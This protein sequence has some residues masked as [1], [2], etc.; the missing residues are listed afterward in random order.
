MNI[1]SVLEVEIQP[2]VF[3]SFEKK[4]ERLK[5]NGEEGREGGTANYCV[6]LR[7]DS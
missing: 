6:I 7:R 5:S 1:V 2:G 4:G 3:E